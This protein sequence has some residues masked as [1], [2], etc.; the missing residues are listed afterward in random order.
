M[1]GPLAWALD[2]EELRR[3]SSDQAQRT[4]DEGNV[5]G[6]ESHTEP[7]TVRS[8]LADIRSQVTAMPIVLRFTVVGAAAAF[9]LGALIGLIVG[10]IAYPPTAWFAIFEL[11]VP[12]GILGAAVGAAAGIVTG[13]IRRMKVSPSPRSSMPQ[14]PR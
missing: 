12:A 1:S 6:F 11:G 5:T 2:I 4:V 9:L 7:M 14:A 8:Q 13:R 10:L 3:G